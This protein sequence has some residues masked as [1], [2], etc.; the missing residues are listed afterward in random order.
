MRGRIVASLSR[1]PVFRVAVL[2]LAA[3]GND[4]DEAAN[5]A[6][7]SPML[8][9]TTLGEQLIAP[10]SEYL[11]M[12]RYANTNEKNGIRQAQICKACHSID[13]NGAN[14]IGPALFGFFGRGVGEQ[15]GFD[16]SPVMDNA[17]FIWTPRALDAWLA[18]PGHFLPGNRMTFAGVFRQQDRDDLIA[19]LLK[20]TSKNNNK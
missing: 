8:S 5:E 11:A 20:A 7:A 17:D 2:T 18:Q 16:Y 10:V 12:E 19:Y 3:C 1:R 14:M 15:A 9:A 13:E 4:A 6:D